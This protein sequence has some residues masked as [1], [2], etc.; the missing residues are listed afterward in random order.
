MHRRTGLP[1]IQP[2]PVHLCQVPDQLR[3]DSTTAPD[4]LLEPSEQNIVGDRVETRSERLHASILGT[5]FFRPHGS[6]QER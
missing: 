3:L 4:H 6:A 5:G 2:T 1:K